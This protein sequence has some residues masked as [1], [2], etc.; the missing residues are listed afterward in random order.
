DAV[1]HVSEPWIKISLESFSSN[2]SFCNR[3]PELQAGN[4]ACISV[5]DNGSGIKKSDMEHI[6]EPF[7]TTKAVDKGTGLGLAMSFGAIQT[8]GGVIQVESHFGEGSVFRIYLPSLESTLRSSSSP[9]N[10]ELVSSRGE[11]ILLADDNQGILNST[12]AVLESLGYQV[13][14]AEDGVEAVDIYRA[15]S[16]A[17]DLAVLDVVMPRMGGVEVAEVIR[18]L[19][20]EAKI[21]FST[22]YD[23]GN[24]LRGNDQ[25]LDVSVLSKPFSMHKLSH[26]IRQC[27]DQ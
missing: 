2:E 10:D 22:G 27:L 17:V 3:Y 8:H 1:E 19:N 14:T 20:P 21:I 9:L 5:A 15:R 23:R 26:A 7:F 18:A 6:F 24:V 25:L 11:C 16:G 4:Y 13:L 12:G